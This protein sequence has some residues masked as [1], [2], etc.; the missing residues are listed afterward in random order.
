MVVDAIMKKARSCLLKQN[1]DKFLSVNTRSDQ[2]V[3][4]AVSL[5]SRKSTD[6]YGT[7]SRKSAYIGSQ[8]SSFN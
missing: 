3:P 5:D 4:P 8:L 6:Y 1:W 2:G 7:T